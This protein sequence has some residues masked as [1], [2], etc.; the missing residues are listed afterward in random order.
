MNTIDAIAMGQANRG[1]PLMVFDWDQ[2]AKYIIEYRPKSVSAG[3]RD[4]WEYTGGDIF[5]DGCILKRSETYVY[6][7][8]T[9]AVPE[10]DFGLGKMPCFI[11]K[12]EAVVR[13][14]DVDMAS[15]YWPQSAIEILAS[16][17]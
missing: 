8:S 3:L 5:V 16:I 11:M 10:I 14:G 9:W 6:L 12:D 1:K 2:A 17:V 4:D 13:W 15:L 7:A